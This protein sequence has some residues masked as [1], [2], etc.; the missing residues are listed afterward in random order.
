MI[1]TPV[2]T[3]SLT[4]APAEGGG[5][6]GRVW[7]DTGNYDI[8]QVEVR[9]SKPFQI[10]VTDG[11]FGVRP[12]IRVEKSEMTLR[13]SRVAF[14]HPDEEL[15]LPTSIETLHLLRGIP[16]IRINQALGNYRRFLTRSEIRPRGF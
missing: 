14:Q 5:H 6:Q 10:P 16:S 1:R 12:A 13:Y 2:R 15:M 4:V 7:F 8:V 11:F 9:L 3:S